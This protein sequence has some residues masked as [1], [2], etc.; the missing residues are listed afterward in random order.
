M[1]KGAYMK[2]QQSFV[3]SVQRQR[4]AVSPDLELL[5]SHQK[6][7]GVTSSTTI[8]GGRSLR[9]A[10]CTRGWQPTYQRPR[11]EP[12]GT[13]MRNDFLVVHGEVTFAVVIVC[14]FVFCCFLSTQEESEHFRETVEEDVKV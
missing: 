1:E 3:T 7:S 4:L 10:Q 5:P 2:K 13:K 6:V 8:A 9:R 11:L 14:L 12:G